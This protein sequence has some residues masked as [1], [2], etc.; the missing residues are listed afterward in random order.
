MATYRK[1]KTRPL[2]FSET[3]PFENPQLRVKSGLSISPSDI[4]RMTDA[5]IA[6]SSLGLNFLDGVESPSFDLPADHLRG[7]DAAEVWEAQQEA[8]RKLRA[9]IGDF[10][11]TFKSE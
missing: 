9:Q 4:K 11:E 1:W 6:S 5:G 7:I 8:R 2:V 10:S 3:K